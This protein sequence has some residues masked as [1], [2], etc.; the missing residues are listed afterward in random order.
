M[1]LV[2]KNIKVVNVLLVLEI[3]IFKEVFE[4]DIKKIIGFINLF[5]KLNEIRI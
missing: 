4:I 3:L 1:Y 5:E 2:N